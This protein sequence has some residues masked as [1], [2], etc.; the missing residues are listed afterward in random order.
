MTYKSLTSFSFSHQD[1]KH[2]YCA[3][4][5]LKLHQEKWRLG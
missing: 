4:F 1:L 5:N 3:L 2:E